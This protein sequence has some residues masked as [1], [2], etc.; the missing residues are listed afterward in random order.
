MIFAW[1]GAIWNPDGIPVSVELQ[2]HEGVHCER[3][4]RGFTDCM[5]WWDRYLQDVGFRYDEELAAHRVEFS[6]FCRRHEN[7]KR[8][9]DYLQK[10]A[11]RLAGPLYGGVV[12]VDEARA[13]ICARGT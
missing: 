12:P 10:I 11:E 1:D 4:G 7:R 3:Q 9:A 2:A 6:T 8:R 5:R 13:A